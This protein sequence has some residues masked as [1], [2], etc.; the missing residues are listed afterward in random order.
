[1]AGK[2][3][4]TDKITNSDAFLDMPLSTQA[5]YFHLNMM[6]DDDGFVNGPKRIARNIG[7]SEDELKL[8]IMKRF[9]IAFETG[10]IVIKHWRM[11]NWIRKDR[12]TNTVYQEEL[13][14]LGIKDNG[15]Y[16]LKKS[17]ALGE[18]EQKE[19][20]CQT[21]VSQMSD[22]MAHSIDQYSVDQS[23]VDKSNKGRFTPPTHA[24]LS[25]FIAENGYSVNPDRFLNFYESKGWLV[26]KTKMKDW[27]A[28]VRN[29]STQDKPKRS[30]PVPD[31]GSSKPAEPMTES[32]LNDYVVILRKHGAS[33]ESIAD[34]IKRKGV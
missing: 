18:N 10:V 33:E 3:M 19:I 4:F 34:F 11:H 23:S 6:A 22:G 29:W 16:T 26:G 27:K 20:E 31:Y 28:A 24:E 5:L 2:R 14:L 25:A 30:E 15:V 17:T 8:L 12:H 32:E 1:M 21:N 9:I 7:S 13:K